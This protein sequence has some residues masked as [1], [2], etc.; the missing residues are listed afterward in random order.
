M[1]A[2][3]GGL[4]TAPRRCAQLATGRRVDVDGPD[5]R[6]AVSATNW[7]LLAGTYTGYHFSSTGT[8]TGSRRYRLSRASSAPAT[9][10]ATRAGKTY[11]YVSAGIWAGYW[12]PAGSGIPVTS[13]AARR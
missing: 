6:Q 13:T 10:S 12:M 5:R 9:R 11:Y 2:A 8:V 3:P 7:C 4:R 1:D